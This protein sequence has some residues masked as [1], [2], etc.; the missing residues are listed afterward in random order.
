[1][2]ISSFLLCLI[3]LQVESS[4]F[5]KCAGNEW[6]E[7]IV[8]KQENDENSCTKANARLF[9]PCAI[10]IARL[11]KLKLD[12][13]IMYHQEWY[14][15]LSEHSKNQ[16]NYFAEAKLLMLARSIEAFQCKMIAHQISSYYPH[17]GIMAAIDLTEDAVLT[18]VLSFAQMSLH[19]KIHNEENLTKMQQRKIGLKFNGP[20]SYD[21]RGT[22]KLW[23]QFQ[24][25]E[26]HFLYQSNRQRRS[27]DETENRSR[28]S[29]EDEE[30]TLINLNTL[31]N[32]E[33]TL[34][35][36]QND[37]NDARDEIKDSV[38]REEMK[39]N[40][41]KAEIATDIGSRI[42]DGFKQQN[43]INEERMD[44]FKPANSS[45]LT[46]IIAVQTLVILGLAFLLLRKP[47]TT[48]TTE[49]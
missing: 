27:A 31:S 18:D 3:Q 23:V 43:E 7:E 13:K 36:L 28:R 4:Y 33:D 16:V 48:I 21:E 39:L 2:K 45:T 47:V 5:E 17:Y 26:S 46:F 24:D 15:M 29:S 49:S 1:M 8:W 9:T 42:K 30:S 44:T 40:M 41:F 22:T 11:S 14:R 19:E 32:L 38:E 10:M 37:I 25:E 35:S 20:S 6:M 12:K 34:R